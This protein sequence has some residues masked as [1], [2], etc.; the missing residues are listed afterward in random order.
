MPEARTVPSGFAEFELDLLQ[1][2]TV[3]D[4]DMYIW[5]ANSV[6]PVLYRS[7][8][9]AFQEEHRQRLAEA[10]T[11]QVFI[12]KENA[13]AL[14]AYIERNLDRIIGSEAIPTSEKAK[15]LYDTSL[16]LAEDVLDHPE[17]HE[18]LRR[19][20]ELVRNM[21]SYVLLGKDAFHQLMALK[22]YDYRTFTHSVNVCTI[23]LAL[24]EKVGFTS[25]SELTDF[26]VGAIFHDVGK[27]RIPPEILGKRG[28]LSESEWVQMKRHPLMGL[29]LIAPHID[30][31]Q[32]AKAVVLQHHERLDGLGY[33]EGRPAKDIHPFAKVAAL[34]DVFD[35]LT[36][37][38]PYKD[39]VESYPAL[40]IMKEEAGDHFEEDYY[41]EFVKLLG[42]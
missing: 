30:F 22:A 12:R 40:K 14:T 6:E 24:A 17:T 21:I 32:D 11:T 28:P 33:P 8:N 31:P 7:R 23:G 18:N 39:A 13:P 42:H 38:R 37:R 35:A 19:S 25:Q 1:L 26:G 36:S 3:V 20:E 10:D 27:T 2:D 41:R 9:M 29:E 4:F 34:A 16:R 5:P 15:I